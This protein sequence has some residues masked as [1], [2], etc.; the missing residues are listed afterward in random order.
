MLKAVSGT[1]EAGERIGDELFDGETEAAI[2]PGELPADPKAV[3][4]GHVPA[5]SLRFPRFRPPKIARD[6]AGRPGP[7]PHIRLD[8]AL[9]FLIGDRL[10]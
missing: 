3:L 1:P 9:D 8:R 6:G 5:G 4:D 7:L 2:Y 10:S